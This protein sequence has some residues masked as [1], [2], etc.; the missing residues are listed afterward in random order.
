VTPIL[1]G[2]A[3][4]FLYNPRK[5]AAGHVGIEKLSNASAN[6]LSRIQGQTLIVQNEAVEFVVTL[7]NPYIFD[8]ELQSLSLR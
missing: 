2:V 1:V 4:P 6:P 5:V 7:Q 8:L 3:D